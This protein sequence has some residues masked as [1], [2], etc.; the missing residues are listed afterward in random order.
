MDVLRCKI[1]GSS[2]ATQELIERNRS[3]IF[4]DTL[5]MPNMCFVMCR[6]CLLFFKIAHTSL[7]ILNKKKLKN[8]PKD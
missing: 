6:F 7:F 4:T 8:Q 1:Y 2:N 5:L 3:R